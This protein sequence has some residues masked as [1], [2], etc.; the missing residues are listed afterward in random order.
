MIQSI[1]Q[2]IVN[3]EPVEGFVY[4]EKLPFPV[5]TILRIGKL[6]VEALCVVSHYQQMKVEL[7]ALP[8]QNYD[9]DDL[10]RWFNEVTRA[11]RH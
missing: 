6:S 10:R 5:D 2:R 8:S 11:V 1:R 3:G 9:F 4:G 7:K